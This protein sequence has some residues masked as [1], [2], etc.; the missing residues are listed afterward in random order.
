MKKIWTKEL[1][2]A[3]TT[4]L[5]IVILWG[6]IQFLKGMNIFGDTHSYTLRFESVDGL[7]VSSP[8]TVNGYKVGVVYDMKYDYKNNTGVSV[9]VNLDKELRIPKG[10]EVKVEKGLL[11]GTTITIAM[12]T[13]S[14]EYYKAGDVIYG[15][16]GNDMMAQIAEMVPLINGAIVKLD[17]ILGGVQTIVHDPAL[18]AAIQDLDD[19]TAQLNSTLASLNGVVTDDVPVI[20]DNINNITE[21]IETLSNDLSELPLAETLE[22]LSNTLANIEE[23]TSALNSTDNTAGLLLNDPQLYEQLNATISSLDSLLIDIKENPKRY[24]N[25]KVF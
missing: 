1:K 11:G 8:V 16:S 3:L 4:I 24:I 14:K 25:I 18:M 21:N 15:K 5:C 20:V 23:A 13:E 12:N 10:S 19:I 6:G 2:I 9:M 7:M 22:E 17:S